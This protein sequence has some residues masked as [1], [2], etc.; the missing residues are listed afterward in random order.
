MCLANHIYRSA[1]Y[2]AE[3]EAWNAFIR[4]LPQSL[5]APIA[6]ANPKLLNE[7]IYNVT[8]I[9]AVLDPEDDGLAVTEKKVCNVH[10][11]DGSDSK[12][13]MKS[14]MG[15]DMWPSNAG[16][17]GAPSVTRTPSRLL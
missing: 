3:Q 15:R 9:Y 14:V 2:F 11:S 17:L 10:V 13:T 7:C 8:Q 4:E 16:V 6:A 5:R 1:P 12:L